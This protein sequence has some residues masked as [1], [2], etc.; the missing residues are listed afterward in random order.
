MPSITTTKKSVL[1]TGANKGIGLE[2][3]HGLARA[4]FTVYLAARNPELGRAAADPLRAEGLDV[5]DLT[6]DITDQA[7][8]DHA[9]ASVRESSTSLDLLI[10]NAGISS[11]GDAPPSTA[12]VEVIERIFATNFLGA[13][14]VTQAF[15]PLLREAASASVI[16]VTSDLGSITRASDPKSAYFGHRLLGYAS[17]KA[18]LNMFTAQLAGELAETAMKVHSVN[19]GYTATDLNGHSGPQSIE[20]GA[21][22]ILRV[23]LHPEQAPTGSYLE[24]AGTIPW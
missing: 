11:A 10:N 5:R 13:I 14:R 18:A 12:S 15:L 7:S 6:L 20:Q 2:V 8:V 24:T 9:A 1:I 4:G 22:E 21:A 17:S 19:P 16:N 23:A 3:A